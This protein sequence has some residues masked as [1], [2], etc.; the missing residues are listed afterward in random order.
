MGRKKNFDTKVVLHQ[1]SLTFIEKGYNGTSIDDLVRATGLLRGSLYSSFGS[2]QGLF[3][4][5]LEYSLNDPENPDNYGLLLVAMLELSSRSKKVKTILLDWLSSH[6]QELVSKE[7][8]L[9]ILQHAHLI[10]E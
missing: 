5:A 4:Q 1:V 9:K 2:K 6:N 7:L 8:G 10:E 3:I